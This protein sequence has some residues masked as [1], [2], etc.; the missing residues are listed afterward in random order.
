MMGRDPPRSNRVKGFLTLNRGL[1][2]CCAL[3]V[4][5][6]LA[7]HL[8]RSRAGNRLDTRGWQMAD[9]LEHL[10]KRGVQLHVVPATEHGGW[11][12][13]AYLTEDPDATW[14]SLQCRIKAVERIH[15][16][17]GTVWVGRAYSWFDAEAALARW[18]EYGCRIGDFLLFGDE[19]LLRRIQEACR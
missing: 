18:G 9:F 6:V 19:R 16:W 8:C 10:Q 14:A 12:G 7:D 2:L 1:S 13:G 15:Q 4:V 11:S 5:L 3:M 17:H